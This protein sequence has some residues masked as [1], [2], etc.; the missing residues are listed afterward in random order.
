VRGQAAHP[1]ANNNAYDESGSGSDDEYG[2]AVHDWVVAADG[3][4]VGGVPDGNPLALAFCGD[5]AARR[6]T[7]KMW[8][9]SRASGVGI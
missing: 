3:D 9:E 6:Y 7:G 8:V 5:G 4:Y 2:W 1:G